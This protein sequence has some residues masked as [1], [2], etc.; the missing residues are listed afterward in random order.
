ML[1]HGMS[2]NLGWFG[3]CLLT[4]WCVLAGSRREAL[5]YWAGTMLLFAAEW[6]WVQPDPGWGAWLAGVTL[7]TAFSLLIRHDRDLLRRL[8]LAQAGLAE[9]ARAEERNRIARELHDVIAHSLTVTLL[10]VAERAAG[11][12]ARPGRRRARPGR[13]RT[14]RPRSAWPRC[15]PRSACS[16]T[17]DAAD[18]RAAAGRRRPARTWSSSSAPP[19]RTSTLTAEGDLAGLPATTGLAVYRIVQEALTNAAKHAPGRVDRVR[20]RVWV[21]VVATVDSP[22]VPGRGA[23]RAR[24]GTRRVSMRERADLGRRHAAPP[25]PAGRGWRCA[26]SCRAGRRRSARDPHP[27]GRRPGT[28]PRRPARALLR[29]SSASRSSASAADG[30]EVAAA[31]RGCRPDVVLMDVRMPRVD[32]VTATGQLREDPRPRR[33][34]RSP[35]STTTRRWPA[36]CAAGAPGS[37][38]RAC[39]P[40]TCSGRCAMVAGRLVARPGRH[41]PGAGRLPVR[42]GRRGPAAGPGPGRA[43]RPRAS[44]CWRRSAGADQRRDRRELF[45]GEGTVKTHVNHLFAKLGCATAPPPW[46][47]PSTTAWSA[48]PAERR[49]SRAAGRG[50]LRHTSHLSLIADTWP[51]W[52]TTTM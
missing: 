40:R 19:A 16:A 27:A 33:C 25:A 6:L 31:V 29:A 10:H 24:P 7:T 8:R 3:V 14:A 26:P 37:C 42:A 36:C 1:G 49:A 46:S 20:L 30:G 51:G 4:G 47:S 11:G 23:A 39:R 50:G 5:A 52:V 2:S 43:H 44:R 38:S 21:G 45:V 22:V 28:R 18:R 41:R 48:A 9:R 32:G 15:A 17:D 35:P 34:S 12:R 13:G